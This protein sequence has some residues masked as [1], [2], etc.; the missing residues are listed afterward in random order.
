[1]GARKEARA[2]LATAREFL[3]AATLELEVDLLTAAAS[4][5]RHLPARRVARAVSRDPQ[6]GSVT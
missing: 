3:D 1:M 6:S 5:G 4:S 2:H